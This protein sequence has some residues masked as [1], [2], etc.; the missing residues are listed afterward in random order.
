MAMAMAEVTL[1]QIL[2]F[3]Q[4]FSLYDVDV[5]TF[6]GTVFEDAL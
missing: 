6:G 2:S 1:N 5:G 3:S 4:I